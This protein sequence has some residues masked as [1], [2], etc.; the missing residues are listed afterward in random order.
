MDTSLYPNFNFILKIHILKDVESHR[1][2]SHRTVGSPFKP[3]VEGRGVGVG[4]W[5]ICKM[6]VNILYGNS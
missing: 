2:P 3:I 4:V 5:Y 1:K 6:W